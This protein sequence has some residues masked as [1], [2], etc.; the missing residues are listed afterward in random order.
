M[1]SLPDYEKKNMA[2][3]VENAKEKVSYDHASHKLTRKKNLTDAC[4]NLRY[5]LLKLA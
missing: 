2:S 5:K 1:D 3:L 4:N